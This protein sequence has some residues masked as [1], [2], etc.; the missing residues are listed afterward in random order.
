[1]TEKCY[2][3]P[4]KDAVGL[5]RYCERHFCDECIDH[6]KKSKY[7]Y[8]K[9]TEECLKYQ[10]SQPTIPSIRASNEKH[11][12][13]KSVVAICLL[14]FILPLIF[15]LSTPSL[16]WTAPF[17]EEMFSVLQNIMRSEGLLTVIYVIISSTGQLIIPGT[18]VA[19]F[20]GYN[21]A[22]WLYL[23][24]SGVLVVGSWSIQGGSPMA[25]LVGFG[26][27]ALIFYYLT[28]PAASAF[29]YAKL[30]QSSKSYGKN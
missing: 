14:L 21:W 13:P 10:E 8:C 6:N 30:G 17:S 25:K 1:M 7:Y 27:Y 24:Y 9:E 3:H 2:H 12:R 19:M 18:A 15:L 29:F 4:A 23:I 20:L 5:C 11:K 28:R 22:R 16:I 26:L